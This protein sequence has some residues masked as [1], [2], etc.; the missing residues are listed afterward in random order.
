LSDVDVVN[1]NM[2]FHND[3]LVWYYITWWFSY[4]PSY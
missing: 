3:T 4:W 1:V 2:N